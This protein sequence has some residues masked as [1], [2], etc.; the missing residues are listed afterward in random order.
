M[1]S[2]GNDHI[3]RVDPVEGARRTKGAR[4]IGTRGGTASQASSWEFS[5]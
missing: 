1:A 4:Q 5:C 2:D 3:D